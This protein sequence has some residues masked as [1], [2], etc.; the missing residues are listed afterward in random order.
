MSDTVI[1]FI[2]RGALWLF[3]PAVGIIAWSALKPNPPEQ[4][5]AKAE[6]FVAYFLLSG[7]ATLGLG[8]GRKLIWAMLG[9]LALG[10]TLEVLQHFVGRDSDTLNMIANVLGATAGLCLAAIFLTLVERSDAE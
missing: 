1:L 8:L 5:W 4:L 2:R 7:L 10:G 9:I 6:H 3:W